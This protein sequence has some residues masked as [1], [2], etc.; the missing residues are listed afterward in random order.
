MSES[1]HTL[2]NRKHI[3]YCYSCSSQIVRIMP[4]LTTKTGNTVYVFVVSMAID[5]VQ[6]CPSIATGGNVD[7]VG[8]LSIAIVDRN[9]LCKLSSNS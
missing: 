8:Y 3:E 7:C 4:S 5:W 1:A 2:V 6:Q 9:I